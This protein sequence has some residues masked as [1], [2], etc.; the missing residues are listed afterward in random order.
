MIMTKDKSQ[1][2]ERLLNITLEIIYLLTGEDY[3]VIKKPVEPGIQSSSPS[4][5][6]AYSRSQSPFMASLQHSLKQ[7][8]DNNKKILE[9]TNKIIQMLTGEVPVRCEDVT[10]FFSMEEWD[11]LEGHKDLYSDMITGNHEPTCSDIMRTSLELD[12]SPEIWCNGETFADKFV[13]RNKEEPHTPISSPVPSIVH[14]N[15]HKTKIKKHPMAKWLRINKPMKRQNKAVRNL[16]E[17][18]DLQEKR[19]LI[20]I[21]GPS[22]YASIHVSEESTSWE[23]ENLGD[24]DIYIPIENSDTDYPSIHIKEEL[25]SWEEAD[26]TNPNIY[27]TTEYIQ[28]EYSPSNVKGESTEEETLTDS[29]LYATAEHLQAKTERMYNY[30]ECQEFFAGHSDLDR[31]RKIH[32]TYKLTCFECEKH[33]RFK[34][35]LVAHQK[36]H[37]EEKQFSYSVHGECLSFGSH[38]APHQI[39]HTLEKPFSCSECGK[40]FSCASHLLIHQR[41]HTGEKPFSCPECGK[42]FSCGSH[43]V[44]HQRIHT[45]EKPFSCGLCGKFFTR[46]SSLIRHKMVHTGEKPFPCALCGKCFTRSSSLVRHQKIHTGEKPYTC[47]ECGKRF[48]DYSSLVRHQVQHTD[49]K[50]IAFH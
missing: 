30:A 26:L 13:E 29:D 33:F 6:E 48:T 22:D 35:D 1:M 34:S 11:Y 4:V 25:G 41:I 14:V 31:A 43:L 27:T 8:K 40:R 45:G 47:S 2:S 23:E 46:S 21:N 17:E 24:I 50:T 38:I 10:I 28:T 36:I 39:L 15:N 37:T 16:V 7:E 9:L 32:K 3:I 5:S 49:K 42:C 18:S 12:C 20:N 44:R 19:K